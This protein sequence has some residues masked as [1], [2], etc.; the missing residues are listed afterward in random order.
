L[1]NG[2]R[3]HTAVIGLRWSRFGQLAGRM[4]TSFNIG[5]DGDDYYLVDVY[6]PEVRVMVIVV[7]A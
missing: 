3:F 2:R 4:T 5:Q 7:E 6:H 1:E